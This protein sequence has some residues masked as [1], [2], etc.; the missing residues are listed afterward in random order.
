MDVLSRRRRISPLKAFR[1]EEAETRRVIRY[2]KFFSRSVIPLE[3]PKKEVKKEM[4]NDDDDDDED[5]EDDAKDDEALRDENHQSDHDAALDD[6]LEDTRDSFSLTP[7]NATIPDDQEREPQPELIN[8]LQ[9]FACTKT[10][11]MTMTSKKA[12]TTPKKAPSKRRFVGLPRVL[13]KPALSRG[14]GT[15]QL[16]LEH[17]K[18]TKS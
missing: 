15:I 16:N 9:H 1:A 8:K 2:S 7:R 5:K 6:T 17:Y 3:K 11:W 14:D 4:K 13:K 10:S 12:K 18:Y